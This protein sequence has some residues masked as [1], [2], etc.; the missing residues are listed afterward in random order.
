MSQYKVRNWS[1]Y[2]ESLK[3]RGSLSLWVS[4]DAIKKWK[5][6]K[7]KGINGAP[8]K[9]SDDAILCIMTL[10]VVY[11]LP[12][13]QLIGFLFSIFS[14]M[15]LDLPIPHFTTVAERA[16]G[17]GSIFKRLSKRRPTDLVLDSSGFKIFGEGEWQ[18]RKHGKQKRRRWMKFHI[19]ICPTTHEIVVADVTDLETADCEVGPSL[20][21]KA[22]RSV[23][24]VIGDGAY[25]T[26][27]NYKTA[28]LKRA[29]LI[30][31]PRVGS[32]V[33]GGMDQWVRDRDRTI[34]EVLGFGGDESALKLWKK[35]K[36]YHRRS[37]VETSFSRLK[38]IFGPRLFSKHVDNQCIELQLKARTMNRMTET[39]MPRGVMI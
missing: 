23:K 28:H 21:K 8:R 9:Y 22:P 31:P 3:N 1:Q 4:E 12:Y 7:T 2:N 36:G 34:D 33:R 14:S 13:R 18:V 29:E 10:K 15:N 27:Q 6:P 16:R 35:L 19:G 39:G 24:R 20:M 17:L 37:L 11:H 30:V 38:G 5:A 32:V 26:F 25:D